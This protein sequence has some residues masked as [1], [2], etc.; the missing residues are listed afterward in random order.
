MTT[1]G[2]VWFVLIALLIAIYYILDGFDLGAG[3]LS[4]FL[5][6][7]EAEKRALVRAIGPVWDGNEVWLLTAGGALFA[8]FAP[9]YA[10]VFS[11]FYLAIMLVLFGLIMRAIA[12]EFRMHDIKFRKVWDWFFFV[13]SLLPA[14]LFGV[15]LGNC[16]QG[17][18][19]DANGNYT[20]GFLALLKPFPLLCGVFGLATILMQGSAWL[21]LKIECGTELQKRARFTRL[22]MQIVV[23]LLF[24]ATSFVALAMQDFVLGAGI[25]LIFKMVGL[26]LVVAG[27]V[28][29]FMGGG[30]GNDFLGF[31]GGSLFCVGIIV[32]FAA[33]MFPDFV[34]SSGAGPT[35]S[36]ATAASSELTLS[37]MS[38]VAC[39]G[40]PLVLVYHILI[41][42]TFRGRIAV[43]K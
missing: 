3:V 13:G 36:I 32:L 14:L 22:I 19:L 23:V 12:L 1:L 33:T 11:G 7:T 41:Y 28:A 34:I 37:V 21:A 5:T 38:I 42:R 25:P 29:A 16:L 4:P 20:G 40:I 26:F 31:A 18:E 2:I 24:A 15:A 39:I 35:I 17:V 6:K 8:A 27:I 43:K 10:C 9:V 30:R